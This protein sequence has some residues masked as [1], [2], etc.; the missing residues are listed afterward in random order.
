MDI[1]TLS[2]EQAATLLTALASARDVSAPGGKA[3]Q[4]TGEAIEKIARY[5]I[6]EPKA[7]GFTHEQKAIQSY[8]NYCRNFDENPPYMPKNKMSFGKW[9]D[10]FRDNESL[11]SDL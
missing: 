6:A 1:N 3:A 9:Y 2:P 8:A 4:A 11:K 5:I 10:T 7:T